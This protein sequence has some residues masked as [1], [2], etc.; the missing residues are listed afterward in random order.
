M[1]EPEPSLT[2]A[3]QRA[4]AHAL[5]AGALVPLLS[6][7]TEHSDGGV[8]FTL[9]WLSSLSLKDLAKLFQPADKPAG[10][11][12]FLP[13]ERDLFV[14][15][16]SATHV[17]I[18]NKFPASRLHLLFITKSFV[19]QESPLDGTDLDAAARA[20]NRMA[21]LV[22]Y[23]SGPSAGAS[24]PHRH[25]QLVVLPDIPM[26]ALFPPDT[27]PFTLQ[28]LPTVPFDHL[29]CRFTPGFFDRPEAA[30]PRL[31]DLVAT[32]YDQAGLRTA[33]GSLRSYNLLMARDWLM[34]VPR[35]TTFVDGILLSGPAYAGV[36]GLRHQEQAETAKQ[37]G[38][39]RLLIEAAGLDP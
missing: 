18:L 38:P 16:L 8:R 9:E 17:A 34:I 6:E 32:A 27:Q 39:M 10:F 15:D 25:L 14:V 26:A 29:F 23:N 3:A 31:A 19:A 4:H 1:Q 11:N 20:L 33:D 13:Y 24:Q 37:T 35:R 36:I 5:A 28:R 22:F 2:E 7:Q 12:P 21:G 30:G